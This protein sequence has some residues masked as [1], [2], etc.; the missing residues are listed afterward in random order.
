MFEEFE[1]FKKIKNV[2]KLSIEN[3]YAILA[4]YQTEMGNMEYDI[5]LGDK[6]IIIDF[7]GKYN[8]KIK[9]FE[10]EIIIERILEEG[11]VEDREPT[12]EKGKK[13]KMAQADRM[14][15][16]IYDLINDYM[17]DEIIDEPITS[18]QKTLRMQ[19]EL[20]NSILWFRFVRVEERFQV[21]DLNNKCV[22]EVDEA[23]INKIYSI[24]NMQNHMEL[25]TVNYSKIK[26]N[27]F[28]IIENP[29]Q[30]TELYLDSTAEKIRFKPTGTGQKVEIKGDYT[31][32][33]FTVELNEIV[34]GAI[35]F[36][37]P[38]IRSDYRIEINDL[39]KE[40]LLLAIAVMLHVFGK[41]DLGKRK[42]QLKIELFKNKIKRL[43]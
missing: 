6:N 21:F 9:A 31:D 29:F 22:F 41:K 23:K 12:K 40:N 11:K 8:A 13:I 24:N 16:Q 1:G 30:I 14:I 17:E 4:D 34:I 3:I 7:K 42:K 27:K 5:S 26:Q 2:K 15:D 43:N 19:L 36:L 32:N 35:D 39:K 28:T 20:K 18:P 10:D 33:H 25:A 38:E 37:D